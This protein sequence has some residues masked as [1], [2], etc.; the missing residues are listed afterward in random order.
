MNGQLKTKQEALPNNSELNNNRLSLDEERERLYLE[1]KVKRA[2]YEAGKSL[3]QLRDRK[4][5]RN[6]HSSFEQYCR[7]RF[8]FKRRHCH[9]LIDAAQVV[10]NLIELLAIDEDCAPM[11]HILP[12]K[13]RQVRPLS[14]LTPQQQTEAWIKAV[15]S[16][17]GKVP[18]SGQ[19]A[20]AA[21]PIKERTA[22]N[23]SE[24]NPHYVGEICRLRVK[25][26]PD[27]REFLGFGGI[28]KEVHNYACTIQ[29]YKG[30]L[31]V[32]NQ[33]LESMNYTLS[34]TEQAKQLYQRL[35]KLRELEPSD[36][37]ALHLLNYLEKQHTLSLTPVQEQL[38]QTLESYYFS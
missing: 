9:Q 27:L 12:T 28:V 19:V 38:L 10:D 18:S 14:S 13:E 20:Q 24:P 23:I 8:G 35:W 6:T 15:E 17:G 2:F 34:E 3:A 21:E 7:D 11:A 32:S 30:E 25:D 36:G 26:N 5:Y 31:L 29:T 16:A 22:Q 33:H 37:A 4:L 1:R